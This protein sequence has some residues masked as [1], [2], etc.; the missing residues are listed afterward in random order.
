M[1]TSFFA[2][3][4]VLVASVL[5]P[6]PGKACSCLA[7]GPPC[8]AFANTPT[9]FAGRVTKISTIY[10]RESFGEYRNR[11]VS[12]EVERSYRG[13]E[14]KT[15]E[16]VTG[17]GHGDCGYDFK[18]GVSYLVYAFHGPENGE[19]GT[20]ICSRTR[21]L[22]KASEDLEFLSRK[23]DPSL[24]AG[25]EGTIAELNAAGQIV[26]YLEGISVLVEGPSGRKAVVS[27]KNGFF[28]LWGLLPGSYRVTPDLPK[29]F[30]PDVKT[31]KT[32]GNSCA[33]VIFLETPR[34]R[35][36]SRKNWE[37]K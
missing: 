27:Q 17:W 1:K 37:E 24:G 11:L 35:L 4:V 10:R 34:F 7:S 6:M 5:L 2:W 12:F 15:A 20:G 25:I 19:L 36:K 13:W 32:E 28:Q 31:V 30:S 16:V 9:I 29:T 21:P 22:S 18:E 23:D 3:S 33:E 8:R 26:D 14:A